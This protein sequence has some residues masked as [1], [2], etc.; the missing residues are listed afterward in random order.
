MSVRPEQCGILV[1][2]QRSENPQ[3]H[4]LTHT[5]AHTRTRTHI[6]KAIFSSCILSPLWCVRRAPCSTR[7]HAHTRTH[8]HT[9]AEP[10]QWK[11]RPLGNLNSLPLECLEKISFQAC[12]AAFRLNSS[13]NLIILAHRPYRASKP[14]NPLAQGLPTARSPAAQKWSANGTEISGG[15][16]WC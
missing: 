14:G 10:C 4:T 16:L 3:E 5:L 6:Y 15:W 8:M 1:V 11:N 13:R 7:T 9:H 2:S 12:T